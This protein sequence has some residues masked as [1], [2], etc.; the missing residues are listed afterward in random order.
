MIFINE[1]SITTSSGLTYSLLE[2]HK[3][4]RQTLGQKKFEDT[5]AKFLK[6]DEK[7]KFTNPRNL[8]G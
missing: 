5:K 4:S 7:H 3:S 2:T 1:Q 6:L 8:A